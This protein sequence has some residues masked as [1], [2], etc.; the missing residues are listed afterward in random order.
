M[1]FTEIW[2]FAA[3][4]SIYS[5][6]VP[7]K[8]DRVTDAHRFLLTCNF[9]QISSLCESAG[10]EAAILIVIA[11]IFVAGLVAF[12]FFMSKFCLFDQL[13]YQQ[14]QRFKKHKLCKFLLK[15]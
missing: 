9:F 1:S 12:V 10:S 3:Q 2:W 14:N 6:F 8:A 15:T 4:R 7:R 5:K 13:I 11:T